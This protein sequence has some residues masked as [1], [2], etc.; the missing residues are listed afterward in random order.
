MRFFFYFFRFRFSSSAF[1]KEMAYSEKK[2]PCR[3]F[4]SASLDIW[5]RYRGRQHSAVPRSEE[6]PQPHNPIVREL[7]C[8][9][10]A[11]RVVGRVLQQPTFRI[12]SLLAN[13]CRR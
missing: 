10:A 8:S 1:Q 5:T 7:P 11:P 12:T 2:S 4:L 13:G 6:Q 3:K 9:L